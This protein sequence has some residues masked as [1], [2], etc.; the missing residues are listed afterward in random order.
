M[1]RTLVLEDLQQAIGVHK[2]TLYKWRQAGLPGFDAG[3]RIHFDPAE[4]SNWLEDNGKAK[5][6][7]A[8]RVWLDKGPTASEPEPEAA[9]P[10]A[11]KPKTSRLD[12]QIRKEIA[13]AIKLELQ[14]D[15]TRGQ[16]VLKAEALRYCATICHAVRQRL[17]ALPDRAALSLVGLDHAAMRDALRRESDHILA[18]L[19][20]DFSALLESAAR[21][22]EEHA[23]DAE[24]DAVDESDE[25]G[26]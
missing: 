23:D 11:E 14:N 10:D 8:L 25:A 12:V 15:I 13:Q 1:S 19:P 6:A 24:P 3:G 21:L 18:A 20:S 17:D 26:S 22:P 16:F 4:V 9:A 5:H 7:R 2:I